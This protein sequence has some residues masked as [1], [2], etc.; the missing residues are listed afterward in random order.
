[1]TVGLDLDQY[2][3][4]LRSSDP[5]PVEDVFEAIDATD[6]RLREARQKS[7]AGGAT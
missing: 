2:Q 3:L 7:D 4:I 6:L 1:M 5:L